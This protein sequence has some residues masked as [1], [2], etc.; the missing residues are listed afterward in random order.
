MS[1]ARTLSDGND[2]VGPSCSRPATDNVERFFIP[3]DPKLES[4]IRKT[5]AD[6]WAR[7]DDRK[8]ATIRAVKAVLQKHPDMTKIGAEK[9][10]KLVQQK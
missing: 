5:L 7:G 6:A 1:F 3:M 10:V 2:R 8:T 9:T 4:L